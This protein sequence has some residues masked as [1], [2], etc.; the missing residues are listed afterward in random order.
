[1]TNKNVVIII[2]IIAI[3]GLFYFMNQPE[4]KQEI[5][6]PSQDSL[7]DV[8]GY[9]D[10]NGN[11]LSFARAFSVIGGVEGVKY[12]TLK[13]SVTNT[14]TV[15]LT[16]KIKSSSPVEINQAVPT[17]PLTVP[18]GATASW[19]TGLIDVEPYET[20][21]QE[22]CVNVESEAIPALRKSSNV[23]GCVSVKV[24]PNPSG[25]FQVSV[26]SSSEISPIINPGCTESWSCSA[27]SA[28]VSSSQSRTCTDANACGTTTTKPAEA[29]S[30]IMPLS[31]KFRT[32]NTAYTN[33]AV[34]Y[35][36][37]C[38]SSLTAYG[39]SGTSTNTCTTNGYTAVGATK[40]GYTIC[41]RLSSP[42]NI[43]IQVGASQ[44]VYDS[45]D[46][47]ASLI[48]TSS[49]S[50]NSANEVTC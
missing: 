9:F 39:Y 25:N 47:D 26:N 17:A 45:G 19:I 28:C 32:T 35:S 46:P 31:V 41:T 5:T 6:D 7:V 38:G 36:A 43:Y 42:E 49:G 27:W 37:T 12:I 15:P 21:T 13:V 11:Q 23:S 24:D 33:G 20:K 18:S 3:V 34:A 10:A 22:F 50:I 48:S 2:G 14:D 44:K 8:N 16:L 30:C 40:E 1:M 29:Q 4:E